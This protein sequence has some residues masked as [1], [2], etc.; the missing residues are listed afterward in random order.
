[1]RLRLRVSGKILH[2]SRLM[3]TRS[4]CRNAQGFTAMVI[5]IM[6]ANDFNLTVVV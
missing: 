6:V 4:A 1:M 3:H 5:V 2:A